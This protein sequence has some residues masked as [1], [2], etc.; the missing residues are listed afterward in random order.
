MAIKDGGPAFPLQHNMFRKYELNDGMSLRD[1]F[2]GQALA[3]ALAN[4]ELL[5]IIDRELGEISTRDG[6][7][8][9]A[10]A[11]ADSMLK[12]REAHE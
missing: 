4:I 5:R 8:R 11:V 3:G 6:V 1:Y 12:A 9:Y 10:L 7:A 2:A